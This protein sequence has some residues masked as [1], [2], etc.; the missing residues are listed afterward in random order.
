MV[1]Q[2]FSLLIL[3]RSPAVQQTSPVFSI[4]QVA[5]VNLVLPAVRPPARE[6]KSTIPPLGR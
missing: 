4:A 3:G 5:E 6:L 2:A 1:A